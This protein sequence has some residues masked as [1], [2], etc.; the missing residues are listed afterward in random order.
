MMLILWQYFAARDPVNEAVQLRE[1]L[2]MSRPTEP[3]CG[4]RHFGV[5]CNR[6]LH[7]RDA[8]AYYDHVPTVTTGTWPMIAPMVV[9][10]DISEDLLTP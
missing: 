2:P 9:W 8:H 10:D 1:E 7:H 4:N 5:P 3:D 6:A